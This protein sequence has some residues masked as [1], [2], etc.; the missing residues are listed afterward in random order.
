MWWQRSRIQMSAGAPYRLILASFA[1]G[2]VG[3]LLS[4]LPLDLATLLVL[5]VLAMVLVL[6]DPIW[7]LYLA[8]LSVPVQDLLLLPGGLSVT[9]AALLLCLASLSLH[10]LGRHEQPLPLGRLFLPLVLFMGVL[11]AAAIFSPYSR[12]EA[13]RETMRWSTVVL[14]YLLTLYALRGA[15]WRLGG[16]ITCLLLAPTLTA[17]IGLGQFW[18]GIGPESFAI[19][20]G[21]VRAYGTIG[22]PNSFAGY[23]NQAWPLAVGVALTALATL[24]TDTSRRRSLI[25]LAG[26]TTAAGLTGA[27]LLVSFSRG[28]WVGAALESSYSPL[29]V[30]TSCLPNC[31]YRCAN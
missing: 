6:I 14:I 17:L 2:G 30:S 5:G 20:A 16:L 7:A 11:A 19:G 21:R 26:A 23:M 27:A 24:W 1:L 13:L 31:G 15:T 8:V 3:L 25:T 18:F 10:T 22:Q 12:S 9:Q 4:L 28:G 29:P